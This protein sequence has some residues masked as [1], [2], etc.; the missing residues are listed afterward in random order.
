MVGLLGIAA[1]VTN[2]IVTN[3]IEMLAFLDH[4]DISQHPTLFW[5]LF[6]LTRILFAAEVVTW[7]IAILGFSIAGW[8]SA[9]IPK[10][11]VV[12]GLLQATAGMLT[13]GFIVSS[14]TDGW[15]TIFIEL[16]ALTGM[17]WFVGVGVYM[18]MRGD[19]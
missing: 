8:Y 13:G 5:L 10:W 4:E 9:T 16:A 1:W 15:A 3:G 2:L 18:V 6:R 7:S 17:V 14:V 11:L 19:K 12:L